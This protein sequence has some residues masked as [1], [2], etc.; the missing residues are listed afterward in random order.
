[1]SDDCLIVEQDGAVLNV[2]MNRPDQLNALN[3]ALVDALRELFVSLFWRTDIRVVVLKGAGRAFSAG[4]DL[5]QDRKAPHERTVTEAL[6]SQRRI[7]EIVNAMRRCPQPIVGLVDGPASGG[8]FAI[9]LA[10]DIRIVTPR[11]K[12]NAAFIRLGLSAC[13]I[14]VSYFLPRMVGSAVA[15]DYMLTGRFITADEALHLRLASRL[16]QPDE[17]ETAGQYFVGEMLHA[18]PIGLRLT[19]D[20]LNYAIDAVGLEAVLAI[21]D[22]NQTLCSRDANFHEGITAFVEKR[23]PVYDNN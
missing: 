23:R 12:M 5:K 4:L 20:A 16:V 14:G 17:I 11:T 10:C 13:D 6:V 21:E 22:R 9:A 19:K 18:S 3:P 1:M 2:T 15:A 7:A 8:G